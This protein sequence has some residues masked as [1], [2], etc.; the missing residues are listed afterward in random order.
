MYAFGGDWIETIYVYVFDTVSMRWMRLPPVTAEEE[1]L[2]VLIDAPSRTKAVPI[3]RTVYVWG[4]ALK[5]GSV[6]LYSFDVDTL[7]WFKPTVSVTVPIALSFHSACVV[8]ESIYVYGGY[9][10]IM[11]IIHNE[12]IPFGY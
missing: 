8:G 4:A 10:H 2:L 12:N 9:S 7:R 6:A 3:E 1:H 11:D 5:E